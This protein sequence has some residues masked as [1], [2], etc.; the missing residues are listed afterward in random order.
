VRGGTECEWGVWAEGGRGGGKAGGGGGGSLG[1]EKERRVTVGVIH[2]VR[3]ARGH[4]LKTRACCAVRLRC[5]RMERI[6]RTS[7]HTAIEGGREGGEGRGGQAR[8][9]EGEG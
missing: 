1:H 5:R 2:G 9:G 8:R 7:Q 4:P 6:L 3:R